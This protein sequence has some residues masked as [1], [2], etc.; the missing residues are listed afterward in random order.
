MKFKVTEGTWTVWSQETKQVNVEL[1]DGRVLGIRRMEDDNGTENYF[2]LKD[3]GEEIYRRGDWKEDYE[4]EWESEEFGEACNR[5]AQSL[6]QGDYT[7]G[8]EVD[9]EELDEIW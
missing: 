2:Q 6:F 8:E 7:D 5:L 4:M 3:A 9:S 1:P